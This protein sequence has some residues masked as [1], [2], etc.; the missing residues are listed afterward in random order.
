MVV[1]VA[2][3]DA[4]AATAV[5]KAAVVAARHLKSWSSSLQHHVRLSYRGL[6][7][8]T[9]LAPNNSKINFFVDDVASDASNNS[10]GTIINRNSALENGQ[11]FDIFV[12]ESC[13]CPDKCQQQT[14]AVA[15]RNT[16]VLNF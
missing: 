1:N 2:P 10:I 6:R 14:T 11:S 9:K 16:G 15:L 8:T 13:G 12:D 3:D 4:S 5:V 7:D